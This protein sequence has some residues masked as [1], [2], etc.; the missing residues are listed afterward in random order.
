MVQEFMKNL[1][2]DEKKK[3]IV[4]ETSTKQKKI[5]KTLVPLWRLEII[6]MQFYKHITAFER[7]KI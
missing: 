6:S 3:K 5:A 4:F 1:L 2:E 7:V